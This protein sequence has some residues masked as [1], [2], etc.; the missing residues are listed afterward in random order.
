MQPARPGPSELQFQP[1]A[2]YNYTACNRYRLGKRARRTKL[3]FGY[4]ETKDY[5]VLHL[6]QLRREH[7]AGL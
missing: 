6:C 1:A 4:T 5:T 7:R 2:A 3:K